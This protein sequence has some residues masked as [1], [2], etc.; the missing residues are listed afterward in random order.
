[1]TIK[2]SQYSIRYIHVRTYYAC[3]V[4]TFLFRSH[5]LNILVDTHINVNI[6]QQVMNGMK[7]ERES[8]K[9]S[10]VCM[11]GSETYE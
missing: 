7:M 8:M 5:D 11:K 1:M 9:S 6:S 2:A 4:Y 3:V 10:S